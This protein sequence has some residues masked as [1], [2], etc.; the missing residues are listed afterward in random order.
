MQ[1]TFMYTHEHIHSYKRMLN[2]CIPAQN[3]ACLHAYVQNQGKRPTALAM[4]SICMY[5]NAH[6]HSNTHNLHTHTHTHTHT[7][8][9]APTHQNLDLISR[10]VPNS[11][12]GAEYIYVCMYV[13]MHMNTSHIAHTHT[14]MH[15]RPPKS[16]SNIRASAQQLK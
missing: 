12:S 16:E 5:A 13:C 14:T 10:H 6:I 1:T 2:T 4:K 7:R 9:N 8:R 11:S 3:E 15:T